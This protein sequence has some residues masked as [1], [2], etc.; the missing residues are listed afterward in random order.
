[1]Y[2]TVSRQ[3]ELI[4][5]SLLSLAEMATA[6]SRVAK[7]TEYT[8]RSKNSTAIDKWAIYRLRKMLPDFT[9][10]TT[11][12]KTNAINGVT[13]IKNVGNTTEAENALLVIK[14]TAL[15]MNVVSLDQLIL[16]EFQLKGAWGKNETLSVNKNEAVKLVCDMF[17]AA[18]CWISIVMSQ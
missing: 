11:Y 7:T 5:Y 18:D 12:T 15:P 17:P 9:V 14:A 10:T 2:R 8:F 13:F 1:M 6:M 3:A 16:A 4:V